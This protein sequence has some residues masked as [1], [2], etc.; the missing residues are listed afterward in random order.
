MVRCGGAAG[1]GRTA[2]QPARY[3]LTGVLGSTLREATSTDSRRV[4][5]VVRLPACVAALMVASEQ[6]CHAPLS[7]YNH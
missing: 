2:V 3:V 4:S 7:K 1:W 5:T 6:A